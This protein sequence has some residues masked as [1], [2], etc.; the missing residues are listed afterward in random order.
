MGAHWVTHQLRRA[1]CVRGKW[2]EVIKSGERDYF[3]EA[4]IRLSYSAL[5]ARID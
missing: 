1:P 3:L 4:F 2:G 5:Y